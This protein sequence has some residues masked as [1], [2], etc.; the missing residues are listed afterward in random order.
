MHFNED[1]DIENKSNR[2][3]GEMEQ[4]HKSETQ[5]KTIQVM[6][7]QCPKYMNLYSTFL[8]YFNKRCNSI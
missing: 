2:I 4:Q 1:V 3:D 6:K 8:K 7:N 5:I